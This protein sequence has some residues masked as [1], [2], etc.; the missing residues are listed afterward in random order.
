METV[1]R[2][3]VWVFGDNVD[4]DQIYP[5]R[6][7]YIRD[8]KEIG[9]H[10]LEGADPSFPQRVR[11]GDIVVGGANFGCGSSREHAAITL[12]EAGV[13]AVVAEYFGRIF[14]RNAFNLGLPVVACPGCRN[15]FADGDII[16]INL[17]EGTV[18][19]ETSGAVLKADRISP[20]V[21]P[22]LEAGGLVAYLKE[23]G[24]FRS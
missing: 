9:R 2:G 21:W 10:V 12:K 19:N 24:S 4:T 11:P 17:L 15:K 23:H 1:I 18:V 22:I 5:G 14:Y 6:L 16:Q 8:R 3:R 20:E 13:A 7:L